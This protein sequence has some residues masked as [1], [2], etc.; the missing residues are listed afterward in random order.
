VGV[1]VI[2]LPLP[3][4]QH[5]TRPALNIID[6]S[7]KFQRMIP[8][9]AKKPPVV[10]EAY[11][12]WIRIFGPSKRIAL[13][14]GR[15][16]RQ[17]FATSAEEDGSFADPAAVEAP[18]QRGITER[19]GK[20]FK[21]MLLKAMDNYNCQSTK[22]W[23]QLIDEVVMTKNR[24]L[25]NNGFSPMQRAFGFSTRIPGGLLSGD[26]G[27]RALPSR[28]R[29]G[30]LSVE[31]AMRMRKAA[32]QAFV[33][34]D[35]DAAL[36][37]AIETG[38]RP[39]EDYQ[40]GE[41][42]YFFRKGADKA[43]KFAPGFWCGPAKIIMVDQPSTIWVAYQSTLVKASPERIRR[44]SAEENLTVSG[45]LKDLVDTKADLAQS[46]NKGIWILQTI[47]YL[48]YKIEWNP[49]TGYEPSEPI[50]D[51]GDL[52]IPRR[53]IPPHLKRLLEREDPPARKRYFTKAPPPQGEPT[54][55]C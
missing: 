52:A 15:E 9:T 16:F 40:I 1:D 22:G 6:W 32:A 14:M 39:M 18:S 21:F 43:R 26:D 50:D 38:P 45:W 33:E 53:P 29:M 24:L 42:V 4:G 2:Y 51:T 17:A 55:F 48:N 3:G 41:M 10:R 36:R 54:T 11:R 13:D 31:R 25:Q 12:Q 34:A 35:A 20:P 27:N 30:D 44:A 28:A 46:R 23:E 7:S 47:L 37:R 49:R 8:L 19:H 5:K